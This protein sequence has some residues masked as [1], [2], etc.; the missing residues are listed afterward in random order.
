MYTPFSVYL[1]APEAPEALLRTYKVHYGLESLQ[2][3]SLVQPKPTTLPVVRR[4]TTAWWA[5][6]CR[7]ER[8]PASRSKLAKWRS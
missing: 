1:P 5:A 7:L 3:A 4:V 6:L 2:L 8:R